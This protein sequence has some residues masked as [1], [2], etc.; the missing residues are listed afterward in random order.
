MQ[1]AFPAY[2][3]GVGTWFG[4]WGMQQVLFSWIVVGELKASNEWV[5]IAQTS[6]MLPALMLLLAGGAV[7]DRL[8]PRRMLITL[9]LLAA[10]P[11]LALS[12]ASALG[13]LSLPLVIAY[14][15]TVGTIQAFVMP[16]RDTL[17][18]RVAGLDMMHA[19]STMTATQFA[20]QALGTL[21]SGLARWTGSATMLGVQA[22]LVASGSFVMS[23]I[24]PGR[25]RPAE[26]RPAFDIRDLAD[27]LRE[28][29]RNPRLRVPTA[30]VVAVGV[31]FIGPFVVVF[32]LLVRDAYQGG[33][34]QL[35]LVLMLFP[36]GT[37]AGSFAMRRY[38]IARK[39]RAALVALLC[40][41]IAIGTIGTGVP[42]PAMVV[43][44]VLW[45]VCGAMF[46]NCSRT[47]FQEASPAKRRG[48]VLAVYQLGFM[49][50]API[51]AIASGFASSAIGLHATLMV[52]GGTMIG[53]VTAL[54]LFSSA[55]AMD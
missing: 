26:A 13:I 32:P 34:D 31:L 24:P 29:A 6:T 23:G 9:H 51:G 22:M 21:V 37:I 47:L 5:G 11:A 33:V 27:G 44:T 39:G 43:L 3:A 54:T 40:G 20:T 2:L 38:G 4:A 35:S 16:A 19:V 53:V 55:R 46:I 7:A 18:S 17:L 49:G 1:G 28:V 36:V 42:F 48:R 30:M 8:D 25:T 41:A 12:A 45:G 10:A 52:A 15:L 14:G 50:G